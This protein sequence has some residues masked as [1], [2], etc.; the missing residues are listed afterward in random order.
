MVDLSL[1]EGAAFE[2]FEKEGCISGGGMRGR[3]CLLLC[4]CSD[5][6][7]PAREVVD[8]CGPGVKVLLQQALHCV[9]LIDGAEVGEVQAYTASAS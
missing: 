9:P 1:G 5:G 2:V 7:P 3:S 6:R 4:R 8:I